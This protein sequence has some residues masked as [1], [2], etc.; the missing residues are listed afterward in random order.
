MIQISRQAGAVADRQSV[1]ALGVNGAGA[2]D[3]VFTI[4]GEDR[5]N[6]PPVAAIILAGR[7]NQKLL[8]PLSKRFL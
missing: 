2:T 7:M 1:F 5:S 4:A 8:L 6:F 3:K